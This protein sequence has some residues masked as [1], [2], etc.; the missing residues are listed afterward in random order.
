MKAAAQDQ[1]KLLDLARTDR[2]IAQAEHRR[3]TLPELAELKDLAV[4]RRTLAEEVVAKST[5]LSD[6]KMEQERIEGDLEP[7]RARMERNQK[8]VDSGSITDHK[9]LKGL[10]EEIEHLGRRISLLE[11]AELEA[12]QAVE[13]AAAA[14]ADADRRRIEL[15]GHI[16]TVLASRDVGLKGIDD[17]LDELRRSRETQAGGIPADLLKVYESLRERTGMGC[18]KLVHGVCEACGIAANGTDLRAYAAAAEDD[19]VRCEECDRI[20][21]RAGESL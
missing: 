16:R 5:A 7:A 9:A 11:D 12:M 15:D 6:A 4:Q 1:W 21:V 8:T 18:A 13:D 3:Q 14:H 2:L 10:M 20:L 19:V 17:E